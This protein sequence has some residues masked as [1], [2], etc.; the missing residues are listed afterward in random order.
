MCHIS[1]CGRGSIRD[2]Q[3]EE[4]LRQSLEPKYAHLHDELH[5]DIN[6]LGPPA[7]AHARIAFALAEIRK[8]LIP[9]YGDS[10]RQD[11]IMEIMTKPK[12]PPMRDS[13][14]EAPVRESMRDERM[15]APPARKPVGILRSKW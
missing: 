3:K 4:E 5:M 9:E 13:M 2:R 6:T 1:I 11:A 10:S 7:E 12:G 14:R 15:D 8:Y